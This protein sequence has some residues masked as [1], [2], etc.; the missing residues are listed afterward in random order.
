M[1]IIHYSKNNTCL[2]A[3]QKKYIIYMCAKSRYGDL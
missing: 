2:K 3:Y 1:F